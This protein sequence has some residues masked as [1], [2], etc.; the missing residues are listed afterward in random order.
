[1]KENAQ[2]ILTWLYP[3]DTTARWVE[4]AELALV[5]PDMT[6]GGLQSV[7]QYLQGRRRILLE[8]FRGTQA[9][10]ITAHGMRALE[11]E[12]PAFSPA[13]RQWKREWQGVFF[14]KAPAQ[15]AHFRFLRRVLLEAGALPLARGMF[16][17][18]GALPE[19]VLFELRNAYE[20]AVTV[21]TFRDWIFG[22]EKEIIGSLL[23]LSDLASTYSSI[24]KEIDTL[25]ASD[26]AINSFNHPQKLLFSSVFNRLFSALQTDTGLQKHYFPQV[27]G[28]VELLFS[29]QHISSLERRE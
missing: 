14:L 27:E 24:S 20:G 10:T 5:A 28:G 4:A 15:D 7:L 22:D 8:R 17:F 6:R 21:V 3:P 13:R 25:L 19:R 1:M 29:L 11:A 18:P 16:I 23:S 9:V 26:T 12:I 2:R